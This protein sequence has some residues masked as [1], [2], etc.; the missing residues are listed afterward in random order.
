MTDDEYWTK[1]ISFLEK[2]IRIQHQKLLF[3]STKGHDESK[4]RHLRDSKPKQ[5]TSLAASNN[6]NEKGSLCSFCGQSD[7]V[8]IAGPQGTKIVQYFASLVC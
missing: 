4:E 8:A 5:Y 3:K 6:N 1:L 7:H 2:D